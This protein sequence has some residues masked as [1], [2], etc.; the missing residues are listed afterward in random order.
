MKSNFPWIIK[1]SLLSLLFLL[2][3]EKNFADQSAII[4]TIDQAAQLCPG[5]NTLVFQPLPNS[6]NSGKIAAPGITYVSPADYCSDNYY[7]AP[8]NISNGAIVGVSYSLLVDN[9]Q[10]G[11]GVF[12]LQQ[13]PFYINCY[14]SYQ[15]VSGNQI[16]VTMV[17]LAPNQR[18][19]GGN[20]AP[21]NNSSTVK[22]QVNQTI[23]K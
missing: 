13:Q 20:C 2:P 8:A 9:P 7:E 21:L 4:T 10:A 1:C 18:H 3:L 12:N 15:G 11:Y 22:T 23:K 17:S 5:L 6:P 14:M 16:Q 19:P